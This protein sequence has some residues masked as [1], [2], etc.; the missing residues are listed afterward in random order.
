M[1]G[2]QFE[3]GQRLPDRIGKERFDELLMR[4]QIADKDTTF[5]WNR[6]EVIELLEKY[7]QKCK[8]LSGQ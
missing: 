1:Y 3:Y 2:N 6:W 7:K 8:D 4:K 5:K